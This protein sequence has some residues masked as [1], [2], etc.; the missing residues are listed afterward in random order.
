MSNSP[1]PSCRSAFPLRVIV[2]RIFLYS[3]TNLAGYRVA[4]Q[5]C[6]GKPLLQQ[7]A[8]QVPLSHSCLSHCL[9]G[10]YRNSHCHRFPRCHTCRIS[11][12]ATLKF[13]RDSFQHVCRRVAVPLRG[14]CELFN[15]GMRP[16]T[17]FKMI[18]YW[19]SNACPS[20]VST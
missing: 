1:N 3:S 4:H 12:L 19:Q 10:N 2:S 9:P 6:F 14:P 7:A 5:N 17:A 20:R 8:M 18:C 15:P 16:E 11:W 13:V